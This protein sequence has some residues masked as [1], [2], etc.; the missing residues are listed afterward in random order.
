MNNDT[1]QSNEQFMPRHT[2]YIR[3]M[4][5]KTGR[6]YRELE[7]EWRK[8]EREFEFSRMRD[9]LKYANLK[10]TNGSVAQ[11]ISRIFEDNVVR[12]EEVEEAE[13]EEIIDTETENE[14]GDDILDEMTDDTEAILE[15]PI[16]G[17]I[18]VDVDVDVEADTDDI[19]SDVSDDDIDAF[20]DGDDDTKEQEPENEGVPNKSMAQQ[21]QN[22]RVGTTTAE[23]PNEVN[24]NE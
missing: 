20:L 3:D 6:S 21:R 24:S 7:A 22:E 4:S 17:D 16:E 2:A 13:T 9:P 11:E 5:T 19:D 14:F 23:A 10:N 12:P 1:E 15:E 18:D 8:A